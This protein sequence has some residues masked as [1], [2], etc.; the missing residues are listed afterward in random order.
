MDGIEDDWLLFWV[1]FGIAVVIAIA[2]V[3]SVEVALRVVGRRSQFAEALR[4]RIRRPLTLTAPLAAMAIAVTYLP[5]PEWADAL[6][7]LFGISVIATG[8]WLAAA[9]FSVVIDFGVS[10]SRLAESETR[11]GRRLRTQVQ[12]IRRLVIAVIVIVALG[13]ILMTFE[14]V[15]ALG[16]SLLASAGIVSIVIGLAAQSV[17]GNVFAGVQLAFSEAIR[18][19]DAV[20][21]DQQWGRVHEITLSYVVVVTWDRRVLVLPCTRFTTLPFENWTKLGNDLS[22]TVEM[23]LDWQA[24]VPMMR[25]QLDR[26][27]AETD[28][29][30]GEVVRVHVTDTSA[31]HILVR[32]LV[33][34]KDAPTLWEL[35]CHVRETLAAWVRDEHSDWVP[36]QRI[37]LDARPT[38]NGPDLTETP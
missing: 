2:V 7:H 6:G 35:R 19:G 26:I 29:W 22:G 4:R 9:A 27:L 15:R 37:R 13:A 11:E 23:I 18:V 32:V 5:D 17:L 20:V 14:T 1:E 34:A 10:R 16:A 31:G 24:S 30:D 3:V 36:L 8:A 12:V 28:L 33:S 25:E 21:V 38:A